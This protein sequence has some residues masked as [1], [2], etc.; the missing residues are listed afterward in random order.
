[1]LELRDR[2]KHVEKQGARGIAR[3][4][5]DALPWH[6]Q[7]DLVRRELT[8]QLHK[9]TQTAAKAIQVIAQHDVD[10]PGANRFHK[11]IEPLVR[12]LASG[13]RVSDHLDI[14]PVVSRAILPERC[15][16]RIGGLLVGRDPCVNNDSLLH[17]FNYAHVHSTLHTKQLSCVRMISHIV[18][19][20]EHSENRRG[21]MCRHY[22]SL[23]WRFGPRGEGSSRS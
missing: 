17:T 7:G 9:M 1:M 19:S 8:E 6:D 23:S 14:L 15:E 20:V 4:R 3:R 22:A 12:D 5:I 16:L 2:S 11:L 18:P 10:L 21:F 13:N